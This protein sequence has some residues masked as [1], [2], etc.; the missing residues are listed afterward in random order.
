MLGTTMTKKMTRINNMP[1]FNAALNRNFGTW[2]NKSY[3]DTF[4]AKDLIFTER[5]ELT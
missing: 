3:Q 4:Y 2:G 5:K 1:L